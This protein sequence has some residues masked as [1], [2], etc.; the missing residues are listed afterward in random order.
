MANSKKNL[1]AEEVNYGNVA[2]RRL[3]DIP[4]YSEEA[5]KNKKFFYIKIINYFDDKYDGY[6]RCTE[7]QFYDY[8]NLER[9]EERQ[10][11]SYNEHIGN[12][13]VPF[14]REIEDENGD[15]IVIEYEDKTA[16]SPS[17][18]AFMNETIRT[19]KSLAKDKYDLKILECLLSGINSDREIAN[20]VGLSRSA[21]QERRT[22]L[23]K[24]FKTEMSSYYEGLKEQESNRTCTYGKRKY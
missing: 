11:N 5:V 23:Q 13:A 21:T 6:I 24:R 18:L 8:R 20:I 16:P 19:A 7:Q 15:V 17:D 3:R 2:Y 4:G 14:E 1:Q 22:K 10:Q 12:N 9:N